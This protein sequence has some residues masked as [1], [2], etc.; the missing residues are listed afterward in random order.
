MKSR[1]NQNH[2]KRLVDENGSILKTREEIEHKLI[3]FY[4][5]LLRS[6]ASE[7]P[8]IHPE[9]MQNGPILNREQQLELITPITKLEIHDALHSI[10]DI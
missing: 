7:L 10:S 3:G 5:N 8:V 6:C 9:V 1:I 4:K 2:I